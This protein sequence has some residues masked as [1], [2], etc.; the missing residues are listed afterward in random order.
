MLREAFDGKPSSHQN[1]A[2]KIEEDEASWR[3]TLQLNSEIQVFS[4]FL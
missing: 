3:K 2:K 1:H 4:S